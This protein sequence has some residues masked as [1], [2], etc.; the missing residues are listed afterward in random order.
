MVVDT[1][2]YDLLEVPPSISQ[3]DL[4]RAYHKLARVAHPDKVAPENRDA[5]SARFREIQEAYDVLRDPESRASYDELGEAHAAHGAAGGAGAGSVD[6]DDLFASMFSG[7]NA[8]GGGMP[9]M[10][11]MGGMHGMHGM[12]GAPGRYPSRRGPQKRDVEHD[13]PISLEDLYRGKSTR[14]RGVRDRVCA[15]CGGSGCRSGHKATSCGSCAGKGT[16]T[17]SMMVGNG[18]FTQQQVE[19]PSCAGAGETVREKDRCKKCKG[20]KVVDETKL[21]E[22]FIDKGMQDGEK[23]VLQGQADEVPGAGA[24]DVIITLRQK[25]HDVFERLGADL[26]A[27][28]RISLAEALTGVSRVVLRHLD[29]R[30]L[31]YTSPVGKVLRPGDVLVVRGEGMPLGR[32]REGFG[33]L[34]LLVDVEFPEDNFLSEKGEYQRLAQL[35]PQKPVGLPAATPNGDLDGGEDD[36]EDE[37]EAVPGDMDEF[38]GDYAQQ[39][40]EDEEAEGM[41][42]NVTQCAQQ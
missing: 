22:L 13:Y 40:S 3:D 4:K 14:M 23:I 35:L 6:L 25:E 7:A 38:G 16:K 5:A 11:G 10:G 1:R 15:A 42:P 31:R 41:D 17:A 39:G 24:G 19:C 20:K 2:L 18:L 8:G 9:G 32:R 26:R 34:Y 36:V 30:R 12:G 33:D 29:G 27:E 21:M 37:L 28:V